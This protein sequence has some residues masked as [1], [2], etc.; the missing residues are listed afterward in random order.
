MRIVELLDGSKIQKT[1]N[2]NSIMK[3]GEW[4]RLHNDELYSFY[5]SHNIL[6]VVK[7]RRLRWAQHV[8]RMEEGRTAFNIFTG[9]IYRKDIFKKA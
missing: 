7:C 6:M 2:V 4:K 1:Y 5:S 3:M 8:A 9:Y